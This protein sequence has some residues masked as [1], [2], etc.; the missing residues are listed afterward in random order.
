MNTI[1]ELLNK[2]S[3]MDWGWWP[4][5]KCRPSKNQYINTAVLIKITA[6]Y[7]TI[8]GL[9][10]AFLQKTAK[11]RIRTFLEHVAKKICCLT[12]CFMSLLHGEGKV[13]NVFKE[14]IGFKGMKRECFKQQNPSVS[15]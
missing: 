15:I 6:F 4:I 8:L 10:I 11:L 13:V 9:L 14:D 1:V 7:G 12:N 5:L 3:D 2:L